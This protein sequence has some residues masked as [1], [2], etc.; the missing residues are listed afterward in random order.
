MQERKDAGEERWRKKGMLDTDRRTQDRWDAGLEGC[1][2]GGRCMAGGLQDCRNAALEGRSNSGGMQ[3]RRNA[4]QVGCMTGGIY[5]TGLMQD[6]RD[7]G[8]ER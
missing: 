3:D 4:G 1:S 2:T 8:L 5:R 6:R 7:V